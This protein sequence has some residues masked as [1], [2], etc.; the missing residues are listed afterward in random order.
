MSL[1]V[2]VATS[3][4]AF[5]GLSSATGQVARRKA[6]GRAGGLREQCACHRHT[7]WPAV[8]RAMTHGGLLHTCLPAACTV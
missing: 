5:L 4:L 3:V 2:A 1:G 6:A 8:L 7:K